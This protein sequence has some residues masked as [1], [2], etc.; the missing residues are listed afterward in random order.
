MSGDER[1]KESPTGANTAAADDS[2]VKDICD[3]FQEYFAV[4]SGSE[5][6]SD[7]EAGAEGKKVKG[8]PRRKT[9]GQAAGNTK[10]RVDEVPESRNKPTENIPTKVLEQLGIYEAADKILGIS[11]GDRQASN[12]TAQFR[13][14]SIRNQQIVFEIFDKLVVQKKMLLPGQPR[15]AEPDEINPIK[16]KWILEAIEAMKKKRK[17]AGGDPYFSPGWLSKAEELPRTLD[18]DSDRYKHW[19]FVNDRIYVVGHILGHCRNNEDAVE[20]YRLLAQTG[21]STAIGALYEVVRLHDFIFS[22]EPHFTTNAFVKVRFSVSRNSPGGDIDL[23]RKG[24]KQIVL[25]NLERVRSVFMNHKCA[26][27]E[28]KVTEEQLTSKFN[29]VIAHTRR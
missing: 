28:K 24:K 3:L 16:G 17:E 15:F 19:K 11:F 22:E 5:S 26:I 1:K 7:E 23:Q 8:T 21:Q 10:R 27:C 13:E 4:S 20:F 25:S 14:R 2:S 29:E 6:E 12:R 9:Q 18:Y